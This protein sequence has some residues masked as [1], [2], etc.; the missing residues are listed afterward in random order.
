MEKKFELN[1]TVSLSNEVN[2]SKQYLISGFEL[3]LD[4]LIIHIDQAH[5]D[6]L[7]TMG[8]DEVPESLHLLEYV[9]RFFHQNEME[10]IQKRIAYA[11]ERRD[12][13]EYYDRMEVQLLDKS[14]NICC[15]IINT[16]SL[17]PGVIKGVGQN[18]TDLKGVKEIITDQT[19]SLNAVIESTDEIVF[20]VKCNGDLMLFNNHFKTMMNNFFDID[21]FSGM[22]ILPELPDSIKEQWAS[23]IQNGCMG[24]KQTSELSIL[25]EDMFHFEISAN[26]ILVN[27]E[28]NAVSF[29]IKDVTEK[30]RM[31][32]WES[33][34]NGVFEQLSR[35]DGMKCVFDSLLN[36]VKRICPAMLGYV[37]KK[38]D[39]DMELVWVS[40]PSLSENYINK[41]PFIP[42]GPL[43][44]SCGL[45]AYSMQPVYISN[46]REFECWEPYRDITL[47]QGFQA[48]H[49]FPVLSKEGMVLGTLGAY[50]KE[51]HELSDFEISLFKRAVNMASVIL[52]KFSFE[53]EVYAKSKQLEELGYSIPGVM[54]IVKMDADGNRKFE[55]VSERV[56]EF[57]KVSKQTALDSYSSIVSNIAE[58]DKLI[59]QEKLKVSL[60]TRQ[61][62][63]T[64]FRL[65][66]D[67]NPE[68]HCFN[69]Q[70][71]NRYNEDGSVITYGSIYDI[72]FQKKVELELKK[73]QK[74][75]KSLIK[76]LDEVVYVL[77]ENDVFLDV[78]AEDETW[79]FKDKKS[80][81]GK[82]FADVLD[83][84]VC[85]LYLEAKIELLEKHES[86]NFSMLFVRNGE[87]LNFCSPINSGK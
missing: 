59:F 76:C 58:D 43:N 14:G 47:L 52:E 82:K 6:M 54:Y 38:N 87:E 12:D 60:D 32:T 44:G 71:V 83:H 53:N 55:F 74:E 10:K 3:D 18:I 85:D 33:I 39:T 27:E 46:I 26:P 49:S 41:I 40:H 28:V 64:E 1:E 9:E 34:E 68:F 5:I 17:R 22:N 61:P 56:G 69:L 63:N 29:F 11:N 51:I 37:T 35:N 66:S 42:I 30:W 81:V 65:R 7:N 45:A 31:S 23:L 13:P 79:L 21:I 84:H 77:D 72:T 86:E 36:G 20:I 15:C 2:T 24:N 70:S 80:L 57:M 8:F 62:L 75:M 50:F 48:C 25:K 78:F 19:A 16:W 73:Q 67:V 4:S